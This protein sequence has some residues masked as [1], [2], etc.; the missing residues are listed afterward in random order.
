M[1]EVKQKRTAK[2]NFNFPTLLT[3]LVQYV[4]MGQAKR[5]KLSSIDNHR[6]AIM[7]ID[8]ALA[9]IM[10][11]SMIISDLIFSNGNK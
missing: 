3:H 1:K 5:R 2:T 6:D 10:I 11:A 9:T 8:A 7:K 4:K